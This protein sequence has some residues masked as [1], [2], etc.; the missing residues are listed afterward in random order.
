MLATGQD[1]GY[2]CCRLARGCNWHVLLLAELRA[3]VGM[4]FCC[5][6]S[7]RQW[8]N[9]R[10][11]ATEEWFWNVVLYGNP[12]GAYTPED[13][14]QKKK[15]ARR[16]WLPLLLVLPASESSLRAFYL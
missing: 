2:R 11:A 16:R 1:A 14:Y 7:R 15:N 5:P 13:T 12:C 9:T 8:Y 10:I 4:A 6:T 3:K